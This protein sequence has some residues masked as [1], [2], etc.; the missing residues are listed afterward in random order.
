MT[1]KQNAMT[2]LNGGLVPSENKKINS[3]KPLAKSTKR[4]KE[5][6]QSNKIRNVK[7]HIAVDTEDSQ[8]RKDTS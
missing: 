1:Q 5:K 7:R 3:D 4:R 6:I 2:Q 8:N